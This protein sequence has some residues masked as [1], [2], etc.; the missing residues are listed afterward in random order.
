MHLFFCP[1]LF[2]C[3]VMW[4]EKEACSRNLGLLVKRLVSMMIDMQIKRAK[5]EAEQNFRTEMAKV[6]RDTQGVQARPTASLASF[7]RS[8]LASA[9]SGK[10]YRARSR[11]Y[12]SQM[13]QVNMRLKALAEISTMHSFAQLCNLNFLSKFARSFAKFCK[14]HKM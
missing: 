9:R 11:L 2:A 1:F 13:L 8:G 3:E 5:Q 14:I 4:I 10:L 12:R 7:L 6:R